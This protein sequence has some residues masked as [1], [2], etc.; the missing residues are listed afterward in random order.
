ME[1][2]SVI[3]PTYNRA[4]YISDAV[5]SVLAQTY[6][7]IELLII[8]DGSCDNTYE[9]VS[10]FLKDHRLHYIK[11]QNSGAAA[12]RNKGLELM[13]GRY[14]AF[15][16]SD[17]IWN[18]NKLDIQLSVLHELPE[19]SLVCSDFS[20]GDNNNIKEKSHIK[21]YFSVFHDYNLDYDDVFA[22]RMTTNIKGLAAYEKVYWSNIYN[23]ILF[24]NMILTST[25]ICRKDIFKCVG[26]FNSKYKTLEDYDLFLRISK[27]YK[28]AFIDKPLIVY[29]YSQ[30]QL[31]GEAFFEK[32]CKN[33]I[34]IF[35]A[36]LS[37]IDD[38]EFHRRFS[39][40]IKKHFSRIYSMQAYYYFSHYNMKPAAQ[41]YWKSVRY[42]PTD[43]KSFIYLLFSLMP[44]NVT[45]FIRK[46][47]SSV[48]L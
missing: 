48:L 36:N 16:D 29:R 23:T 44:A 12:A 5:E 22:N 13:T 42:N 21:S 25:C 2:V 26:F 4:K 28:V 30:N 11:Q 34:D 6:R 8:D 27:Y 19:V 15:I 39:E 38:K 31:S 1:L 46:M 3:M 32:L 41:S 9:V 7:N 24:G 14:V 40:R 43:Y 33:L 20:C 37:G 10:P 45:R 18:S 47:K 17:D 35:N